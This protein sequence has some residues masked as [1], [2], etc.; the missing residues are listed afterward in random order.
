MTSVGVRVPMLDA[1][2]RVRGTAM[3]AGNVELPGALV[4]KI[5]RS[6]HAHARIVRL[7]ATRAERLPGVVAILTAEK[8]LASPLNP[9]YGPVLPDRPL[10]ALEKVRFA[11][12]PVA[13]VAARDEATAEEALALIEVEYEP[14]PALITPDEAIAPE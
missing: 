2:E 7:D 14:L 8:L 13:A 3:F 12:E 10:V 1:G 5:L 6:P 11:G 9:Y 4:G